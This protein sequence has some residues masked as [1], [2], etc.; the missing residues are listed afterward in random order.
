MSVRNYYYYYY[1]VKT[2]KQYNTTVYVH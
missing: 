1:V 2:L